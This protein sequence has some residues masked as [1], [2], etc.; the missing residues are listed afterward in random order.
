MAMSREEKLNSE[1]TAGPPAHENESDSKGLGF[2]RPGAIW[3][4]T[5]KRGPFGYRAELKS[6]ADGGQ[7]VIQPQV[8]AKMKS[9]RRRPGDPFN[10]DAFEPCIAE[11][12][13]QPL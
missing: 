5:V 7:Q 12:L 10:V 6:I 2:D 11:Q 13:F 3:L 8:V 1:R 4:M 9:A